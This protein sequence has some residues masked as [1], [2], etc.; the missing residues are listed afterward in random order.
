MRNCCTVCDERLR[1]W[2]RVLGR[3]DHPGCRSKVTAK[4][5][6]GEKDDAGDSYPVGLQLLKPQ[7]V[8]GMTFPPDD[9]RPESGEETR[10]APNSP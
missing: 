9:W 5:P 10:P 8:W 3:F 2:E 7:N 4:K 6:V 1:I